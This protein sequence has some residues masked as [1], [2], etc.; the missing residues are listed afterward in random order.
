MYVFIYLYVCVK[1]V[2]KHKGALP[3]QQYKFMCVKFY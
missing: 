2:Q 1:L 3:L